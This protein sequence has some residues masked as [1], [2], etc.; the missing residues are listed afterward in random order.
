M[1][2]A[3]VQIYQTAAKL[4]GEA[5]EQTVAALRAALQ[6]RHSAVWVL[7]GGTT[8]KLAYEI[9]AANY[10]DAIDWSKVVVLMGDERIVSLAH[11]DSNWRQASP[12]LDALGISDENRFV[13]RTEGGAQS[14]AEEYDQLLR[15]LQRLDVVWLGVGEDGHTL[16]LFPGRESGAHSLAMPV[17][18]SP[19]PPADRMSLTLTALKKAKT[20]FI[21]A[22]GGGKAPVIARAQNG[23]TSLPVAQAAQTITRHGGTVMW[24]LDTA[25][26]GA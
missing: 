8:P 12:Y 13:P 9:L 17:H 24:L 19:K 3:T 22:A 2:S 18:N 1:S 20:C 6:E 7:A 16:S 4:A 5:A 11:K 10:A 15:Q 23:D 14:A 21:L 26:A 25:A